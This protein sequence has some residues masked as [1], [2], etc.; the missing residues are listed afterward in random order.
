VIEPIAGLFGWRMGEVKVF[1]LN[2]LGD[3]TT[4]LAG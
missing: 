4:W 2:Q 1:P 3:A